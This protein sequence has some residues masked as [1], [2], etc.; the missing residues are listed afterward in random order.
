LIWLRAYLLSSES[1]F[2]FVKLAK[3]TLFFDICKKMSLF[4]LGNIKMRPEGRILYSFG[5]VF[6]CGADDD[7]GV[8][9]RR[10]CSRFVLFRGG[11]FS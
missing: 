10:V 3:I 1:A 6:I 8:V 9:W 5:T 7:A 11:A 2:L 4:C